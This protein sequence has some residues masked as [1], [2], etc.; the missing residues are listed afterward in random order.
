MR[1]SRRLPRI[2]VG[3]RLEGE[4]RWARI[5]DRAT[6]V[7]RLATRD[8]VDKNT[9]HRLASRVRAETRRARRRHRVGS[10]IVGSIDRARVSTPARRARRPRRRR[11]DRRLTT[12]TRCARARYIR[13][14]RL[15]R[16]N[17]RPGTRA[18]PSLG[19]RR[20]RTFDDDARASAYLGRY[21]SALNE[22]ANDDDGNE[23]SR[24]LDDRRRNARVWEETRVR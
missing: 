4:A 23:T 7:S 24:G 8:R 2:I 22:S 5:A 13:A 21:L 18:P 11:T 9:N 10:P 12:R 15:R 14:S 20:R 1:V 6:T 16:R 19:P 3:S 17:A